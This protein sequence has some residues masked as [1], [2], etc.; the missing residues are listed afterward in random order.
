M[1][2]ELARKLADEQ[3]NKPYSFYCSYSTFKCTIC[4]KTFETQRGCS[5]HITKI[6]YIDEDSDDEWNLFYRCRGSFVR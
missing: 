5:I 6:H 3:L 4:G 2:K 1:I